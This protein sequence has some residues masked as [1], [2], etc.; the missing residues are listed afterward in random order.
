MKAALNRVCLV[1]FFQLCL[2]MSC[3][4]AEGITITI[5]EEVRVDGP[6]MT[7]AEVAHIRGDDSERIK[8]LGQLKIG[9]AATPGNH[10]ILTQEL[11]SMR[12]AVTGLDLNNIA[13]NIP[14]I[15]TVTTNFQTINGQSVVDKGIMTIKN[16]IG[17]SVD[18]ADLSVLPIGT[19]Q[20]M[21]TP[22]GDSV[23]TSSLPSG[24]RYNAPTMV[25]MTVNVNGQ[26]FSTTNLR[27]DVK[28]YRQV[29]VAA[30]QVRAGEIL[31]SENLRYERMD[32]GHLKTGYFTDMSKVIGLETRRP[33]TPGMVVTDLMLNKP[34]VIKR[35]D[36]VNIIVRIGGMEV[37]VVGKAMQD[38]YVGQLIRIQN[39][40]SNKFISAK[41]LDETTVQVLTST[42]FI[43]K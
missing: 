13:W 35:G 10:M 17:S 31:T 43:R 19:V 18:S 42:N 40:N 36:L 3:T 22:V 1:L 8:S 27:F 14:P 38:G 33:L 28:L 16:Q 26:V 23:L 5:P 24:I 12:L 4:F 15:V 25:R 7:L 9:S 11:L 29:A 34:N 32:T 39:T 6:F 2:F 21:I 37:I 41:V 30:H 20:D